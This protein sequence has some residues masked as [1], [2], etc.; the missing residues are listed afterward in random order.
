M[1]SQPVPGSDLGA[2]RRGEWARGGGRER[3]PASGPHGNGHGFLGV[4]GDTSINHNEWALLD[5]DSNLFL[6]IT[7]QSRK[8]NID[9]ILVKL[10]N[11][12]HFKRL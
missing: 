11:Y 12:S 5:P 9:W 1:R 4:F 8:W 2:G 6:K 3:K 10:K 7:E